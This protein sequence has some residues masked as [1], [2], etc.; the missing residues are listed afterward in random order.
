MIGWMT[1]GG[2]RRCRARVIAPPP[3]RGHGCVGSAHWPILGE[4]GLAFLR[5]RC[6]NPVVHRTI[7]RL[8]L[9]P[10]SFNKDLTRIALFVSAIPSIMDNEHAYGGKQM[11]N[12]TQTNSPGWIKKKF[13]DFGMGEMFAPLAVDRLEEDDALLSKAVI[14]LHV[15]HHYPIINTARHLMDVVAA[16]DQL[17][18]GDNIVFAVGGVVF[19]THDQERIFTIP[20]NTTKFLRVS[21]DPTCGDLVACTSTTDGTGLTPLARK[22]VCAFTLTEGAETD[23]EGTGGGASSPTSMRILKAVKG[24][25]GTVPTITLYANDGHCVSGSS[26]P[27]TPPTPTYVV[28]PAQYERD[29]PWAAKSVSVAAD[30]YTLLSPSQ[31]LVNVGGFGLYIE[32]QQALDLSQ[33]ATWDTTAATDYTVADNRAGKDFYVYACYNSDTLKLI[34]SANSTYPDGYTP[35]SSRKIGGFHCLCKSVGT[36]TGHGLSDYLTG[37]ILPAS[38]WDLKHRPAS[39][40]EG[41]LY[42]EGIGKWVD[43]YLASVSSSKLVSIYNTTCADGASSPAFHWYKFSQWFGAIKKRMLTQTEFVAAS[44]GS[45]QGTNVA[46]SADP[47]TTGGKSDTA[48]RRMISNVGCEDCCG[49]LWQWG[50]EPGGGALT[51]AWVN[52]YDGNDSGVAG[53]GYQVP[54][55]AVAGGSWNAGALCGSRGSA[56]AYGPLLLSAGLGARGVSAPQAVSI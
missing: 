4:N 23:P 19:N 27:V 41:M 45:N 21:V 31:L 48:G 49:N 8:P 25:A 39:A 6:S 54:N 3:S 43:I 29:V 28:T 26:Q 32:T 53:Q 24:A 34:V 18:L 37:D 11:T 20:D 51:A 36:I 52:A 15:L 10:I 12:V 14:D 46:G 9:A 56:W 44:L 22:Q 5:K 2:N 16:A 17:T 55:R 13:H 47:V 30:R 7:A 38:V 35:T 1:L 33:A 42:V 50:E 40:P